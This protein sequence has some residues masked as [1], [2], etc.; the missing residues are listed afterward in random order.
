MLFRDLGQ[1]QLCSLVGMCDLR[2]SEVCRGDR[3]RGVDDRRTDRAGRRLGRRLRSRCE[4]M[5]D[6]VVEELPMSNGQIGGR[7]VL[8][9]LTSFAI[10]ALGC[11]A[12]G[13]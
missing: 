3:D 12:A 11:S 2:I 7:L 1:S 4:P 5:F 10:R 9:S 6:R 13:G 8:G